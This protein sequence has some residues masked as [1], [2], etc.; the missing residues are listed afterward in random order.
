MYSKKSFAIM[1]FIVNW[2]YAA[3]VSTVDPPAAQ[4]MPE[5]VDVDGLLAGKRMTFRKPML[6]PIRSHRSHMGVLAE[7][8]QTRIATLR[9]VS[10]GQFPKRAPDG[11]EVE[12][13][14]LPP[15]LILFHDKSLRARFNIP[16]DSDNDDADDT[17]D[18]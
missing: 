4:V 9:K 6:Q 2:W 18:K 14:E 15:L 13:Q 16:P 10:N 12:R 11:V 7:E 5:K 8:L 17:D 1:S 3:P